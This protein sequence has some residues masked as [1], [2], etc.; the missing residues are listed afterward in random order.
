[1]G[2]LKPFSLACVN[3]RQPIA[4][5]L[6]TIFANTASVL[7]IGS[8]TGQHAVHFAPLLRHLVWQPSDCAENLPGIHAWIEDCPS[9]NLRHPLALNVD[10]TWPAASFDGFFTAN[11]C[12]I[13][14]WQS[15]V[16]MFAGI[17]RLARSPATLAIY[18]PFKYRG[19]F[20]TESNARFDAWLKSQAAHQGVRDV[21]DIIR[22]AA[23]IGFQ[24]LEDNPMPA[25]NQLLVFSRS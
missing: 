16:N 20:T 7:E 12:H 19:H 11:T 9:D 13:M 21:E 2:G 10:D 25:N 23:D 1:M 14:P 24:L 4:D 3:N 6:L 5:I 17:G 22:L 15:V 8:G 18:G